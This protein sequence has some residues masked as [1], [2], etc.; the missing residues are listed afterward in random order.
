[1]WIMGVELVAT[2]MKDAYRKAR[3]ILIHGSSIATIG[4]VLAGGAFAQ[5]TAP[6]V[7]LSQ[8]QPS[9]VASPFI[10]VDAP[11][12]EGAATDAAPAADANKDAKK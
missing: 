9:A 11:S 7:T 5:E 4:L 8:P 3:V 10:T 12:A 1:M 6:A 2:E